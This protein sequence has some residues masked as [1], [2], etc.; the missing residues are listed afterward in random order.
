VITFFEGLALFVSGGTLTGLGLLGCDVLKLVAR[1]RNVEDGNLREDAEERKL[2]DEGTQL[3]QRVDDLEKAVKF[4]AKALPHDTLTSWDESD[5]STRACI[6]P[7][8]SR[9]G[10]TIAHALRP[11]SPPLPTFDDCFLGD[12]CGG[13]SRCQGPM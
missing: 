11:S 10:A 3:C 12:Q 9:P 4:L 6:A 8:S 2:H 7:P 1:V 13:C 5:N